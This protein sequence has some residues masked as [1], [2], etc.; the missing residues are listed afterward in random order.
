VSGTEYIA[1]LTVP[2]NDTEIP[3]DKV[4]D[5]VSTTIGVMVGLSVGLALPL[6]IG[7]LLIVAWMM[8][9]S[10]KNLARTVNEIAVAPE[11]DIILPKSGLFHSSE[12][13]MILTNMKRL[14]AALRFGN[15]EWNKSKL[16]L[17]LQNILELEEVMLKLQNHTGLGVVQNNHANILRQMASRRK[18]EA[19][20]LLSQ[21]ASLYKSAIENA[22][23]PS[24][25]Q[26]DCNTKQTTN[27]SI[28]MTNLNSVSTN[29]KVLSRQL[30]LAIVH[31][32]Q[33]LL[34]TNEDQLD[35]SLA[36]FENVLEEYAKVE[37]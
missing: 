8:S 32:D 18:D 24:G 35:E 17:E 6:G 9:S 30:G 25:I 5:E 29:S 27:P 1:F 3:A 12:L 33:S 15:L 14:L 16:D 7:F 31:M 2:L 26:T 20:D 28:K 4:W 19:R 10:L 23:N 13:V 22:K 36:I 11:N 34:E 21:A 37:N